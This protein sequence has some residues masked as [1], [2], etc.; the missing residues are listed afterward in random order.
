MLRL[1]RCLMVCLVA[2]V[3]LLAGCLDQSR[4]FEESLGK[5]VAVK[6]QPYRPDAEYAGVLRDCMSVIEAQD[7]CR[8][9][10]LPPMGYPDLE[11]PTVDAVMDRVLVSHDW[12]GERFEALLQTLP[13]DMLRLFRSTTAIV[14]GS[15]IRPSYYSSWRGAIFIDPN[16]L[17]LTPEERDTI[18][19]TPDF[20]SGFGEELQYDMPWRYVRDNDYA[21]E[22]VPVTRAE[23]ESRTLDDIRLSLARLLYHELAHAVDY[24]SP[25]R[26]AAASGEER[27]ASFARPTISLDLSEAHPLTAEAMFG[28]AKVMFSG[29]DSTDRQRNYTPADI[30]EVFAPD[31]AVEDYAYLTIRED[32]AMLFEAVMAYRHFGMKMD[33]AATPRAGDDTSTDEL[34]VVWG[35]RNRIGLPRLQARARAVF[36]QA[37]PEL[38]ADDYLLGIEPP[39][40]LVSG[41]S[42]HE[43]L[44][45]QTLSPSS[46]PRRAAPDLHRGA[47]HP[48]LS[49]TARE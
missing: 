6:A 36:E 41:A 35:Q 2:G 38:D 24:L 30:A 42:W 37:L 10:R 23:V 34:E 14:I 11:V 27:M 26:I 17:W 29:E 39:T 19:L 48:P 15:E 1:G 28:L 5:M 25:A 49:G 22:W 3:L 16:Y 4:A 32:M 47:P 46:E 9:S 31:N 20:R 43:N 21:Y 12:M 40:E 7:S 33:V 45:P 44:D 13:A 8:F 18:D